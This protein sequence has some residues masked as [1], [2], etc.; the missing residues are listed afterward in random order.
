MLDLNVRLHRAVHTRSRF[1]QEMNTKI[2]NTNDKQME[3]QTI[4]N[5]KQ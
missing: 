4:Q 1:T 5:G 3:E 2:K